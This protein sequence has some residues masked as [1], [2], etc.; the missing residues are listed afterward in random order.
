[1]SWSSGITS[2][3]HDL[4]LWNLLNPAQQEH[5]PSSRC[6]ATVLLGLL[7]PLHHCDLPLRQ[8]KDVGDLVDGLL[9]L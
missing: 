1:M 8:D 5:R 9:S 3:P 6:T 4:R 2:L 7:N